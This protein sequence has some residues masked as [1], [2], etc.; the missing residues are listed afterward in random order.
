MLPS[1]RACEYP[2]ER[3]RVQTSTPLLQSFLLP[4]YMRAGLKPTWIESGS[5]VYMRQVGIKRRIFS[6]QYPAL[7]VSSLYNN[8][9]TKKRER[10]RA[11]TGVCVCPVFFH[12]AYNRS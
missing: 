5:D 6:Y 12:L 9:I 2:V 7:P 10:E 11:K 3:G 1:I 8:T 4:H